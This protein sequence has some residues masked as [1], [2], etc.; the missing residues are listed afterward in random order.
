MKKTISLL[1]MSLIGL[2]ASVDGD[3]VIRLT[4]EGNDPI[5]VGTQLAQQALS[6]GAAE[7]IK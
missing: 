3:C 5:E 2:V 1:L 7:L 4:A 6:Q